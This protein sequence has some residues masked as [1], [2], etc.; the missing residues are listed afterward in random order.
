[1]K[2]NNN[3]LKYTLAIILILNMFFLSGC[4]DSREL[5]DLFIVEGTSIDLAENDEYELTLQIGKTQSTTVSGQQASTVSP[6]IINANNKSIFDA[7]MTLNEN[8]S[9]G[10]LFDHNLVLILGQDVATNGFGDLLDVFIRVQ[11]A[12]IETPVIIVQNEKGSS[13]LKTNIEENKISAQFVLKIFDGLTLVSKLYKTRIIDIMYSYLSDSNAGTIPMVKITTKDG[14]D[15][16]EFAGFAILKD[17]KMVGQFS[18]LQARGFVIAKGKSTSLI[19]NAQSEDGL[20][21]YKTQLTESKIKVKT[22]ENNSVEIGVDINGN[23]ELSEL[24]GFLGLTEM[25]LAEK[26]KQ[27]AEQKAKSLIEES[28]LI[29]QNLRADIYG[30]GDKIWKTNPKVWKTIKNNWDEIYS[31]AIFKVNVKFNLIGLGDIFQSL[32]IEQDIHDEE[33]NVGGN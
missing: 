6:L 3:I 9:K 22:N 32:T 33:Y 15:V 1:M 7:L 20:A 17:G 21:G 12:R 25:E 16:I 5:D 31:Q 30:I 23:I 4:W 26:I 19:F 24:R 8:C 13:V 11:E 27:L 28:I 18:P 2:T 29:S 10:L 14:K